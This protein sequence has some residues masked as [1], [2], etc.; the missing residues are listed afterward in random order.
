MSTA[1][2]DEPARAVPAS[3]GSGRFL[4][5]LLTIGNASCGLIAIHFALVPY[6]LAVGGFLL[7]AMLFD[8]LDGAAA[9]RFGSWHSQGHLVDTAAD[10]VTMAAAPA[11]LVWSAVS[12]ADTAYALL[13]LAAALV[14]VACAFARLVNFAARAHAKPVFTGLPSPGG[15]IMVLLLV[16]LFGPTPFLVG[17]PI[18]LAALVMGLSPLMLVPVAYPK[19]RGRWVAPAAIAGL[20]FGVPAILAYLTTLSYES[21]Y[22]KAGALVALAYFLGYAISGPAVALAAKVRSTDATG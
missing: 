7:L 6:Y 11:V 22:I 19:V 14:Y 21:P 8:A 1:S 2:L 12:R 15:L 17:H 16:F 3:E 18:L 5:D 10:M 20:I 4:A 9:R 13:A